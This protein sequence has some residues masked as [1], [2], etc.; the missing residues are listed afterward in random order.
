MSVDDKAPQLQDV[1]DAQV[2]IQPHAVETPVLRSDHIDEL[3]GAEV[4]FKC[5]N[6]QRIGAFKFRGACNAVLALT[7]E[8]RA[9]GVATHSS[10]NHAAALAAAAKLA[11]AKATI[12]MPSD[13]PAVKQR[14]VAELGADIIFCEP[15]QAAREST[16]D[17]FMAKS[18]A[19]MV[20]PYNDF[21]V[22]S[23]QG[24]AA[25]E[26]L[27]A[28]PDLDVV[29]TPVGGGGLLS[30]TSIAVGE[31]EPNTVVWGAEPAQADDAFRSLKGGEL[32]LGETPSTIADGLRTSLGPLTFKVLGERV[33]RIILAEEAAIIDAM[34]LVWE[35][36]KIVIEPSAAVPV[37]ALLAHP[38]HGFRRIGVILSG[39]NLDLETLPWQ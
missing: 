6:F 8:Q 22:I 11:N 1:R 24:T 16:L 13:A 4:F 9:A 3:I 23:G 27:N 14:S 32:I 18:G 30:G 36:L 12:V 20:H 5:E 34:R 28:T 21:F 39:G 7:P 25:L 38:D 37:A 33:Q 31:T 17:A 26:L 35:R 15:T 2:R 29:V 10:G 19:T